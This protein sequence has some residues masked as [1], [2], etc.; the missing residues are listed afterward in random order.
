[1]GRMNNLIMDL[2]EAIRGGYMSFHE[3]AQRFEVPYDWVLTV[4]EEMAE[5][6]YSE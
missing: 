1:M 6:E 5:Q 4:A 2:Q 3:I